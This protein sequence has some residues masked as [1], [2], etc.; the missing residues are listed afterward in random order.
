VYSLEVAVV[1]TEGVMTIDDSHRDFVMAASKAQ[2][3]GYVAD[4]SRLVDFVGSTPAGDMAL[5]ALRGPL[6]EETQAWLMRLSMGSPTVHATAA[7]GHHRLMLAKAYDL[8][9]RIKAPVALPIAPQD[10]RGQL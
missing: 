2:G 9:A 4:G 10:L 7:E 6:Y 3:M 8:S 5:G 1:G